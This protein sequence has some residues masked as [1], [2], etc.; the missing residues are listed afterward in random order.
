MY[1]YNSIEWVARDLW[2]CKLPLSSDHALGLKSVYCHKS[3]ASYYNY[4]ILICTST[5]T[6][7]W[8]LCVNAICCQ[9]VFQQAVE[10]PAPER[11][12]LLFGSYQPRD[13]VENE[14]CKSANSC[15]LE[16]LVAWQEK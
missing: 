2:Q 10:L 13:T 12:M 8:V 14:M 16:W 5:Y 7:L 1:M 4:N 3:L 6:G 11:D 9:L 15:L